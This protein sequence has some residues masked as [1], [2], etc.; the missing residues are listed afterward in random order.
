MPKQKFTSMDVRAMVGCLSGRNADGTPNASIPT[1]VLK[2]QIANVYDLSSSGSKA[3][4]LKLKGRDSK[5]D[6]MKRAE[7][8][9][10]QG[11]GQGSAEGQAILKS[12]N[13]KNL[14]AHPFSSVFAYS[15]RILPLK[16]SLTKKNT[17]KW[18]CM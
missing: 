9:E 6:V 1:N 12:T 15:A 18:M 2:Y 3:F 13:F 10:M 14:H 11:A 8:A 7:T 5:R 16:S 17:A 4:V